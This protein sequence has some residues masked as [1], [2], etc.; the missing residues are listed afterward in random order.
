MQ[1]VNSLF[2]LLR[3]PCYSSGMRLLGLR[4]AREKRL[5]TQ[6][7]LAEKAGVSPTTVAN[8][9]L[10]KADAQFRTVKK[11]AAALEVDPQELVA[12]GT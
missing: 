1:S 7:E 2:T 3:Q 10:G 6:R 5:M 11:L 8:I 12:A 4:A 9:E